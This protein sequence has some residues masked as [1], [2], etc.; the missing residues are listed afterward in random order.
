M[1][2]LVSLAT[3]ILGTALSLLVAD[4]VLSYLPNLENK[5]TRWYL[6]HALTNT[7]V[8][9][10]V[11]P[12]VVT[13]FLDP[14]NSLSGEYSDVPLAITVGLHVFH[15]ASSYKTLT[16]IDW[17]HHLISNML[18]AGLC[19]PFEYGAYTNFPCAYY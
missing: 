2:G 7:V 11:W 16:L 19:F 17:M 6:L 5:Q 1:I 12:D 8:T 15:C 10:L 14:V 4:L 9:I 18:V 13:T 3:V